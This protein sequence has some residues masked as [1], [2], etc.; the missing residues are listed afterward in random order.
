MRV[1][2]SLGHK[3]SAPS[4]ALINF[5]RPQK[6]KIK[7]TA[8]IGRRVQKW[9]MQSNKNCNARSM[10]HKKSSRG[11]LSRFHVYKAPCKLNKP[12]AVTF[13]RTA[14]LVNVCGGCGSG[15]RGQNTLRTL[16]Y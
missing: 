10:R 13:S 14:V 5:E 6:L 16:S 11:C 4:R 12:H 15:E 3:N 7:L 1:N 8:Y 9:L 2:K